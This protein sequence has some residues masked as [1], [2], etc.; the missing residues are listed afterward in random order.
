MSEAPCN[1]SIALYIPIQ[2]NSNFKGVH[3]QLKSRQSV[4]WAG[5]EHGY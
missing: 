1:N 2:G 5:A 3:S 4:S